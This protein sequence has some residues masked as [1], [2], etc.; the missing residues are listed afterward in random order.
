MADRLSAEATLM[1]KLR[2]AEPAIAAGADPYAATGLILEG[3][4][5]NHKSSN[6]CSS[7]HAVHL[8]PS[9]HFTVFHVCS[10][11]RLTVGGSLS[12]LL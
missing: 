2:R 7:T 12:V 1:A 8:S 10:T 9:P 3:T 6:T 11:S 4:T 5:N